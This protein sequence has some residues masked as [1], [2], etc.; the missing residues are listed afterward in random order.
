MLS[1]QSHVIQGALK[2][3]LDLIQ[4]IKVTFHTLYPDQPK[5]LR[6]GHV[7]K[8]ILSALNLNADGLSCQLVSEALL[9]LGYHKV[10]IC[11]TLFYRRRGSV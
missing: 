5:R 6:R 7:Q 9:E 3:R 2:E 10:K 4:S 1:S 11:G 8:E